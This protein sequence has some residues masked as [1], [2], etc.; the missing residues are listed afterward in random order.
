[1]FDWLKKLFSKKSEEINFSEFAIID[2]SQI[3]KKYNIQDD[4]NK[5]IQFYTSDNYGTKV[6]KTLPYSKAR[7]KSLQETYNIPI[8]DK[9]QDEQKFPVVGQ[10]SLTTASY[11]L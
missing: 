5:I 2:Y 8:Y 11:K 9:T 1:M 7:V 6:I 4:Q 3:S 10:V